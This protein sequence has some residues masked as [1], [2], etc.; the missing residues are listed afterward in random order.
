MASACAAIASIM[1]VAFSKLVTCDFLLH[2]IKRI[3]CAV[4]HR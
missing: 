1:P 2:F 4:Q 3:Y